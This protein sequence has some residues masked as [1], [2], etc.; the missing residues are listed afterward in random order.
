MGLY[1]RIHPGRTSYANGSPSVPQPRVAP[2][3]LLLRSEGKL[4]ALYF[5]NIARVILP[6]DS[7]L[8]Q[9]QEEERKALQ[10]K[11]K[12]VTGHANLTMGYLEHGLGWTPSY[13]FHYKMTRKHRSR[14]KPYWSTTPKI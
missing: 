8:Q 10:F 7:I 13:L 1:P 12:G 11:I 9:S 4:L 14:C 5:H 2:E 3:F 6:A